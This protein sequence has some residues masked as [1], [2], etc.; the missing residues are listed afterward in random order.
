MVNVR[1][2]LTVLSHFQILKHEI[3]LSEYLDKLITRAQQKILKSWLLLNSRILNLAGLC[4]FPNS[5]ARHKVCERY[6]SQYHNRSSNCKQSSNRVLLNWIFKS[7]YLKR[8][9]ICPWV[10]FLDITVGSIMRLKIFY[11]RLLL[12][13]FPS[14]IFEECAV[15]T[16]I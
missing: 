11:N 9:I 12:F 6:R 4:V 15:N 10:L 8:L 14:F 13:T 5:P 7:L 2:V 1:Q 3:C 16:A